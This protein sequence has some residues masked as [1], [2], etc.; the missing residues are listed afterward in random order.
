MYSG[1]QS[2]SLA[3]LVKNMAS[4]ITVSRGLKVFQEEK[5]NWAQNKNVKMHDKIRSDE[6]CAQKCSVS[7]SSFLL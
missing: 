1:Y 3:F 6:K 7:K 5:D 2:V 4:E